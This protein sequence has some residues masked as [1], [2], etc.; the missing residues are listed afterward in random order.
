[1]KNLYSILFREKFEELSL[2]IYPWYHIFQRRN[3]YLFELRCVKW[4]L[5]VYKELSVYRVLC[6]YKVPLTDC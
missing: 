2:M 1:M 3:L 6:V 4:V 5:S